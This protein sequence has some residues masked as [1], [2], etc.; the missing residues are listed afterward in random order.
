MQKAIDSGH[1]SGGLYH[2]ERGSKEIACSSS[3]FYLDIHCP[4]SY[5]SLQNL[6]MLVPTLGHVSSLD[7]D[8]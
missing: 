6:K 4:L 2:L 1:E 7:Y 3:I 8:S 5:S